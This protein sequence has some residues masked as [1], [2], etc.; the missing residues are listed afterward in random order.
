MTDTAAAVIR[1]S[2]GGE[3]DVSLALQRKRVPELASQLADKVVT[4]DLGVHTGFSVHM[5]P[6]DEERIDA[7]P[8]VQRLLE[9]LRAGRSSFRQG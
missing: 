2:Q 6:A 4:V 3:D 7:H 5:K 9:D 8:E 1:K